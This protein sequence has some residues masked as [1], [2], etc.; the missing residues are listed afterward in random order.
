MEGWRESLRLPISLVFF[1]FLVGI[2]N[3]LDTSTRLFFFYAS[4]GSYPLSTYLKPIFFLSQAALFIYFVKEL[5]FSHKWASLGGNLR[6]LLDFQLVVVIASLLLYVDI[7]L[8]DVVGIS[9]PAIYIGLIWYLLYMIG[10]GVSGF[11]FSFTLFKTR[12]FKIFSIVL[13]TIG[14]AFLA[15]PMENLYFWAQTHLNYALPYFVVLYGMFAPHLLM[16]FTLFIAFAIV[17]L[18][19]KKGNNWSSVLRNSKLYIAS[20][21]ILLPV[22]LNQFK[23]GLPDTIIRALVSW[24][25]GYVGFDWYSVSLYLLAFVVY[26]YLIVYLASHLDNSLA[27]KLILF[28][29]I[30]FPWN[31]IIVLFLGYSSL[32]GNLISLDSAVLGLLLLK[33]PEVGGG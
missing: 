8:A 11:Y 33:K 7:V 31:G 29:L 10:L 17:Y 32:P 3:L 20:A 9:L 26:I 27:S 5:R 19:A 14:M 12:N 23:E 25:L 16:A 30:S 6:S 2:A 4:I 13:F 24:G 28:G 22:F 1:S 15:K 21:A 18:R